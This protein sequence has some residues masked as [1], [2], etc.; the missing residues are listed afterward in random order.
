VKRIG[1]PFDHGSDD[2]Y[3]AEQ[4]F[5]FDG[6]E[7]D[8]DERQTRFLINCLF[9]SR[10]WPKDQLTY[11]LWLVLITD[12]FRSDS[13]ILMNL[14]RNQMGDRL[15]FLLAIGLFDS[16]RWKELAYCLSLVLMTDI[17]WSNHL[18]WMDLSGN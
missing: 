8:V 9:H 14:G 1:L 11:S 13:L 15:N 18:I 16:S 5:D 17:L 10:W 2:R 12:I 4:P 3:I 7:W 6:I